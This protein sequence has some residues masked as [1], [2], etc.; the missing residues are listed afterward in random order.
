MSWIDPAL[1]GIM[2]ELHF[3]KPAPVRKLFW[4]KASD[5]REQRLF[6]TYSCNEQFKLQH[7]Y[8]YSPFCC[9]AWVLILSN[10]TATNSCTNLFCT[11]WCGMRRL[12]ELNIT[13]P[14]W[15][16]FIHLYFHSTNELMP[17]QFV[18]NKFVQ[19]FVAVSLLILKFPIIEV[20]LIKLNENVNINSTYPFITSLSWTLISLLSISLFYYYFLNWFPNILWKVKKVYGRG[21]WERISFSQRNWMRLLFG[22]M[23]IWWWILA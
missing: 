20:N 19:E 12:V 17:R 16:V 15:F 8:N 6:G 18:Q 23:Q 22:H 13:W 5:L 2:C 10:D 11:N 9:K 7:S 1:Q 4:F 3:L 21:L 14:T